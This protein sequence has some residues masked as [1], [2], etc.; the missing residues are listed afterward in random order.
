[1]ASSA[2]NVNIK[3]DTQADTSGI[4]QTERSL[5][6]LSAES[7]RSV[8][9]TSGLSSAFSGFSGAVA[10]VGAAF[11]G[12]QIISKI[13]QFGSMAV[14]SAAQLQETSQSFGVLIGNTQTANKL[15]A[16]LATYANNTP[17]E[18]ADV[19]KAG[20]TL[21]GF[22][23]DAKEVM[24]TT[25][26]LGDISAVTGANLGSLSTVYGQVIGA[27]KLQAQD[28]HQLINMGI[29]INQMLQK[30]GINTKNLGD[31]F[32]K[33]GI[34]AETLTKAFQQADTKGSFAFNGTAV[35]AQTFNGRISTM[36]DTVADFGR[37]LLGVKIDPELG[38]T[39]QQGG[40]FDR[41]AGAVSSVS[42]ALAKFAPIAGGF[43]AK[44]VTLG[45]DAA[46]SL[47][48]GFKVRLSQAIDIVSIMKKKIQ[49]GDWDGLGEQISTGFL[50]AMMSLI[51][52]AK[53]LYV[54]ITNMLG[55]VDWM[56][57]GM[58][59]GSKV[60]PSLALGLIAGFINMDFGRL[61]KG[62]ADHWQEVAM[63][64]LAIAFAPAKIIGKLAAILGKI[65][66]AGKLLE[67]GLVAFNDFG[68]S[69]MRW[70]GEKLGLMGSAFIDG[71]GLQAPRVVPAM[72]HF[73]QNIPRAIGNFIGTVDN[74]I[75]EMMIS[76]GSRMADVGPRQVV[77]AMNSVK[78]ALFDA[79]SGA[80]GWLWNAGT[81]IVEGL[82]GGIRSAVSGIG[83]ALGTAVR[84][85][86][87]AVH[88]PGFDKGGFTGIGG[89]T[90]VAGIVH[91]GE[92]V[93]PA[94]GVDQRTGQPKGMAGSTT[95]HNHY[96]N[97]YL[98]SPSAVTE[99]FKQIDRDNILVNKGL[100]AAR[101]MN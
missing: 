74:K 61:F 47:A 71:L 81:R 44:F 97:V 79:M 57:I 78:N 66:L 95:T 30:V 73:L 67:W 85:A 17:F 29:P 76:M 59:I 20:K 43:A 83:G 82:L 31:I 91:K 64:L 93:I 16:D 101:G 3:I 25:K 96:G 98:G 88:I 10:A 19:A 49:D 45:T 62:I 15:F 24:K 36:K 21:L 100:T 1:M 77:G 86:L 14:N 65:P 5:N 40:L 41:L 33:G 38:L 11:A 48:D 12:Y 54:A 9:H 92:Y 72:I 37:Q 26:N 27:G 53:H 94:S 51:K 70:V 8:A 50:H 7:E 2:N 39:I 52:H 18:F 80:G 63:A 69:I 55:K 42:N 75:G 13:E 87:H 84:A 99:Y 56:G 68:H 90:E 58:Y 32:Q 34:D 28:W 60:I 89:V 23:I 46:N 4:T 22:G 35:L 6:T